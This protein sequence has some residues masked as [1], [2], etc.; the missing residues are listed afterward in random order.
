MYI[1]QGN[2]LDRY[3]DPIVESDLT[4]DYTGGTSLGTASTTL[5]A[6]IQGIDKVRSISIFTYVS[7][8]LVYSSSPPTFTY[9]LYVRPFESSQW[10][11]H[12]SQSFSTSY[13]YGASVD[14]NNSRVNFD[15]LNV[16]DMKFECSLSCTSVDGIN[17][18]VRIDYIGKS[19]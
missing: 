19:Y 2:I 7:S 8:G 9:R 4:R 13:P 12:T 15:P 1:E 3:S 5:A 14:P 17:C 18:P 6:I 16:R 11:F 10:F